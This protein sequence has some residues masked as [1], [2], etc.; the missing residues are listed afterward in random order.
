MKNYDR[1]IED[2]LMFYPSGIPVVAL[3]A[4]RKGEP[5][6]EQSLKGKFAGAAITSGLEPDMFRKLARVLL[7]TGRAYLQ[8]GY[9]RVREG[10][11]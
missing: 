11:K 4:Y 5:M 3:Q 10:I 7:Q 2:I 8:D 6:A 1:Q 9:F